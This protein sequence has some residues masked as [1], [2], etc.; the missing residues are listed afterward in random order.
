MAAVIPATPRH[1]LHNYRCFLPDLAEFVALRCEGTNITTIGGEGGI[2]TR[3]RDEP[4]HTFQACSL[5]RSD[6]SPKKG[7]Q[8]KL[9][10]LIW[11]LAFTI[12]V[13]N[14]STPS[15]KNT[16]F[17]EYWRVKDSLTVSQMVL[18]L[19]HFQ[20]VLIACLGVLSLG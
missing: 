12:I 4:T 8:V 15:Y 17:L 7:A 16:D 14:D 2:R 5:S 9:E 11:Q 10:C 19:L 20:K 13:L 1:P 6:T 18:L 3:G